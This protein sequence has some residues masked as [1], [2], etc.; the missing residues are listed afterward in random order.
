MLERARELVQMGA[1]PRETVGNEI[2]R[3]LVDLYASEQIWNM[4]GATMLPL[5]KENNPR[6]YEK[7]VVST[8]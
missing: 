4:Q 5:V 1:I 7:T 2:H 8:G 6:T 3:E